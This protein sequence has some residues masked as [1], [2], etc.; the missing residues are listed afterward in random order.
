MSQATAFFDVAQSA[1]D[2]ICAQ[3]DDIAVDDE[4]YPGCPCWS[5][6]SAGE[7]SI[8]CCDTKCDGG[9]M[10]TVHVEDV[11]PSDNF[12]LP[13]STFEP[14]KAGTW[15]AVL[16][17]TLSRCTPSQDDQ[18]NVD[19]DGIAASARLLA[20]DQYAAL[21]ALGCCLVN[22]PPPGKQK[23]RVLIQDSRSLVSEGGCASVEIRAAVEAGRACSCTS[24]SS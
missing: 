20:I 12:P 1:L 15:V 10:L 16:V 24:G 7:P 17:V 2:C 18:G 22:D 13:I 3:M 14:C 23:R 8:D 19:T 9:G 6:V 4:T 21:T 5:Y 11:F